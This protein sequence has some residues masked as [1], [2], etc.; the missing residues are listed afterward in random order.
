MIL[1][2]YR[3]GAIL[4]LSFLAV[5]LLSRQSLKS[6]CGHRQQTSNLAYATLLTGYAGHADYYHEA[7]RLLGYQLMHDPKTRSPANFVALVTETVPQAQIDLFLRDGIIVKVVDTVTE[8]SE[9]IDWFEFGE[10]RWSEVFAK[11]HLW[12]LTEYSKVIFLDCDTI[13][14]GS[15]D[16][17]F[18]AEPQTL[19]KA[20]NV[21]PFTGNYSAPPE[22][23]SYLLASIEEAKPGHKYPPDEA[24]Y[25]MKDY[26]NAGFFILQP[27]RKLF[28]HYLSLLA[29]PNSFPLV[30]PEQDFIN[31]VHRRD[32][33]GS[34][35]WSKMSSHWNIKF[36]TYQDV[37]GGVLS[38]H[39]K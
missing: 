24:D 14:L 30:C 39:E 1:R 15:L 27:D 20:N 3:K 13:L 17:V 34:I 38:I 12:E 7:V 33:S 32:G 11:L 37:L 31:N 9:W 35:P 25:T 10:M 26:F 21:N 29:I 23:E 5:Y 28:Q 4:F 2:H 6:R 18:D 22:I 8:A 36:P 16:G 19:V